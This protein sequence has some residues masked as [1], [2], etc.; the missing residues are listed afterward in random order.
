M[1]EP[2]VGCG[3]A[4]VKDGR[5]L[6]MRRLKAP[7]AGCWGIAG[8]K[9]DLYETASEAARREIAEELGVQIAADRLLCLVDQIDREAGEHW[10]SPVFLAERFSGEP[11]ILEPHKHEGL[12]WFDLSAPPEPL[13]A[14]AAAAIAALRAR[15]KAP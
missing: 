6:L 5:I 12:G 1:M 14:A 8:G 11:C 10:L 9:V 3:A 13:T 4:I 2:R 7:E 15:A